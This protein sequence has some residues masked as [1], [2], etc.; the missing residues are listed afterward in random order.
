M[1]DSNDKQ[2]VLRNMQVI[3]IHEKCIEDNCEDT[4]S[5]NERSYFAEWQKTQ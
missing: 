3:R 4:K 1:S 5:G 2:M